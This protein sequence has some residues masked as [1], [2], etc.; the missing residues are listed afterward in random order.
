MNKFSPEEEMENKSVVKPKQA[1]KKVPKSRKSSKQP[2]KGAATVR[3]SLAQ[4]SAD[5][6]S[7]GGTSSS[8][9]PKGKT[10]SLVDGSSFHLEKKKK[11]GKRSPKSERDVSVAASTKTAEKTKS[12]KRKKSK[13]RKK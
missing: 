1:K 3:D 9:A 10:S 5:D 4:P 13:G 7:V 2:R 6:T 11:S 8:V 12:D